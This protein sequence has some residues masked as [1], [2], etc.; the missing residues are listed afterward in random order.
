MHATRRVGRTTRRVK[1]RVPIFP[2]FSDVEWEPVS[3]RV[4]SVSWRSDSVMEG[5]DELFIQLGESKTIFL[6]QEQLVEL[7]IRLGESDADSL[8]SRIERELVELMP[9]LTSSRE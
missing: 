7:F 9:Y 6:A 3:R 1:S 8:S 2:L 5:L 4:D